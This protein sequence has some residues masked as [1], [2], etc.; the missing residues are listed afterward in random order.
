MPKGKSPSKP[1]RRGTAVYIAIQTKVDEL[2]EQH[3]D[4]I[5]QWPNPSKLF[6]EFE[7]SMEPYGDSRSQ[8]LQ[9]F[10]TLYN[11]L[12]KDKFRL[13]GELFHSNM[14]ILCSTTWT[15]HANII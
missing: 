15:L 12:T 5:K 8:R 6:E 11:K 7:L 10:R 4:D 9:K 1:L 13:H 14:F 2:W 3:H